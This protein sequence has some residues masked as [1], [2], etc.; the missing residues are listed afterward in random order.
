MGPVFM[1]VGLEGTAILRPPQKTGSTADGINRMLWE[2]GR[3]SKADIA[4]SSAES[5]V[6]PL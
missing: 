2:P 1:H 5:L 3:V 6:G 4:G